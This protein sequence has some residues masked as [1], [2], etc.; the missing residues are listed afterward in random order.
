MVWT[1]RDK[2][3]EA[4]GMRSAIV[5]KFE[6]EGVTSESRGIKR[7]GTFNWKQWFGGFACHGNWIPTNL[8]QG[9]QE[10]NLGGIS[11]QQRVNSETFLFHPID[12]RSFCSFVS[13]GGPQNP[14]FC[15]SGWSL[16]LPL[17]STKRR[18]HLFAQASQ[19]HAYHQRLTYRVTGKRG[20]QSKRATAS[21][22]NLPLRQTTLAAQLWG[23]H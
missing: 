17:I 21:T 23:G 6:A 12:G 7:Q 11:L 2:N 5:E 8:S 22:P 14:F 10:H 18:G 20:L 19:E 16:L 13:C 1:A 15:S 3:L 9:K 4:E